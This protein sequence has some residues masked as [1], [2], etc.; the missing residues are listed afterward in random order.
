MT[1]QNI[2]LN[3]QIDEP[4]TISDYDPIWAQRF[5]QEKAV[6]L[7]AIAERVVTIERFGSTAVPGLAAKPIVDILIDVCPDHSRAGEHWL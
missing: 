5:A 1:D 2:K 4:I 3:M 6:I 7:S